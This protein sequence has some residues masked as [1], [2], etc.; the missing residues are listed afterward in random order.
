MLVAGHT[1]SPT[2]RS[3][4]IRSATLRD[5]HI[6]NTIFT[7]TMPIVG[8]R[9]RLTGLARARGIFTVAENSSIIAFYSAFPKDEGMTLWIDF[10]GVRPS[11][12]GRGIGR[13]MIAHC[14]EMAVAIGALRIG[15]KPMDGTARSFYTRVGFVH[16]S[17]GSSMSK[18]LSKSICRTPEGLVHRFGRYRFN[19][20][21]ELWH[22]ILASVLFFASEIIRTITIILQTG[23][24]ALLKSVP[25]KLARL[26]P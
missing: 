26:L 10:F 16:T 5:I 9:R 23:Y 12:Q 8:R 19:N 20:P 13:A 6:I 22:I 11:A 1:H 3:L 2:E 4:E 7:Q 24:S 17:H 25:V 21:S 18:R 14:E 15:L